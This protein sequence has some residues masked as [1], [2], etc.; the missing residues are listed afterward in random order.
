MS[1]REI[2]AAE[3]PSFLADFSRS[4]RAWRAVVERDDSGPGGG[5]GGERPLESITPQVRGGQ[6]ATIELQFQDAVDAGALRIDAPSRVRV[7]ESRIG[8]V[9]GLEIVDAHGASTRIRFRAAPLPEMLDGIA[10]GELPES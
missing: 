7:D 1:V 2:P 3:W 9:Q 8:T 4:H 6:V 10:P 5:E